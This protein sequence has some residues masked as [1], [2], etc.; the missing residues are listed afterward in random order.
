MCWDSSFVSGIQSACEFGVG[1][2]KEDFRNCKNFVI[3]TKK[4]IVQKERLPWFTWNIVNHHRKSEPY[5]CEI[6][7]LSRA[8]LCK[9]GFLWNEFNQYETVFGR[10]SISR[11]DHLRHLP[12]AFEPCAN[13]WSK[14]RKMHCCHQCSLQPRDAH[15][16]H[17][18]ALI[19][20]LIECNGQLDR[21][22]LACEFLSFQC[23]RRWTF[24]AVESKKLP[25]FTLSIHWILD[26]FWFEVGDELISI[27]TQNA[28][29]LIEMV[30]MFIWAA[31]W[32]IQKLIWFDLIC[33][34][35]FLAG[36][37]R[38]NQL[39]GVFING[40]P[41][42]NHTRLKIVEMAAAGIRPCV[43]SRQLRVSHGCVSKILNRYQET[44]SI[45]PGVIGGSKPKVASPEIESRIEDLKKVNPNIFSNEIRE[46]LIKVSDRWCY[47]ARSLSVSL[48]ATPI[49]SNTDTDPKMAVTN[50]WHAGE[51]GKDLC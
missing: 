47:E 5:F 49:C 2:W 39:G 14:W 12:I 27:K 35:V 19:S 29:D 6:V 25:A 42:P 3:E 48:F 45:R 41:L 26:S 1:R 28:F 40:R 46:R 36:Q 11:W 13:R 22:T 20:Q 51:W 44:G 43:I 16:T 38:V 34:H 33:I 7:R 23:N 50:E 30:E 31:L 24:H 8:S 17:D 4:V 15:R 9:N 32:I 37:G 18:D 10:L 21:K